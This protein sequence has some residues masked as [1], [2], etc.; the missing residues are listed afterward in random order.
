M[1]KEKKIKIA[2]KEYLYSTKNTKD[3]DRISSILVKEFNKASRELKTL[4]E[5]VDKLRRERDRIEFLQE[6]IE[7]EKISMVTKEKN[8][9]LDKYNLK[10]SYE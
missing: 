2:G 1:R 8:K 9:D 7:I 6:E 10:K 5:E 3:I 4:R